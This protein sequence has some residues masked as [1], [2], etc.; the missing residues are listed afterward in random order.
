MQKKIKELEQ[1]I[2]MGVS[3]ANSSQDEYEPKHEEK[4]QTKSLLKNK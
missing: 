4:K 1:M 2:G 3:V